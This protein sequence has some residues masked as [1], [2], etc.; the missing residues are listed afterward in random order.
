MKKLL[1]MLL[2]VTILLPVYSAS[3]DHPTVVRPEYLGIYEAATHA[4]AE[5]IPY[6]DNRD[7]NGYLAEGEFVFEDAQ[8]GL[9]AYLSPTLQVEIVRF[10]MAKPAQRWFVCDVRF[11]P[12]Q[13]QFTQ[14][15][16]ITSS[17]PGKVEKYGQTLAQ[18]NKLVIGINS[19]FYFYRQQEGHVLGNII[20]QGKVI[21]NLTKKRSD[22]FPNLDTMVLHNDGRMTVYDHNEITAD[23]ILAQGDV[24]DALSFGP[25]FIR[26]GELRDYKGKNYDYLAPRTGIGMVEP[27]HYILLIVEAG[28]EADKNREG[29]EAKGFTLPEVA[30]M[31]Y[32]YGCVQ[33]FNLDGGNTS[34]LMFMG[35][36]L[37]RTGNMSTGYPA[38]PR[39]INE[40]FGIGTSDQVRTDWLHGKPKQ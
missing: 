3:A 34:Q 5:S 15:V 17:R 18:V 23:E 36:K 4:D 6:P 33:G 9:W 1:A 11:D 16:D 37:N 22:S 10:K 29:I 7:E 20:R 21:S 8:N 19:D 39:M 40:L 12:E 27:G 13:E 24:H 25:W 2:L 35:E 32:A 28:M 38:S 31:L 30:K 14:K 26:D